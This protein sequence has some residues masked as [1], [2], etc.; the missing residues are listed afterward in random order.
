MCGVALDL[1]FLRKQL[2]DLRSQIAGLRSQV[3]GEAGKPDEDD[4]FPRPHHHLRPAS[5]VDAV[6]W[7]CDAEI[8]MRCSL[9]AVRCRLM[10][11][12]FDRVGMLSLRVE[13]AE[14]SGT[15]LRD[16]IHRSGV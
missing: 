14:S 4:D 13:N 1:T 5:R 16:E 15:I 8:E 12:A 6:C 3:C 7:R 11:C 2:S 9:F 10:R